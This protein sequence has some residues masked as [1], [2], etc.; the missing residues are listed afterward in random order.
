MC[1][2][3]TARHDQANHEAR[4]DLMAN[5]APL[6]LAAAQVAA[7]AISWDPGEG[8]G[9]RPDPARLPLIQSIDRRDFIGG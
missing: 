4:I 8:V 9:M 1:K 5:S 2:H 7:R 6:E 3:P